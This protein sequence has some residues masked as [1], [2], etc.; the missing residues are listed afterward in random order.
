MMYAAL[1]QMC[2]TSNPT[3]TRNLIVERYGRSDE[4]MLLAKLEEIKSKDPGAVAHLECEDSGEVI[5][6][7]LQTTQ[8][9]ETFTRFPEILQ[10]DI[11]YKINKNQ[12]PVCD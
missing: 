7:L 6:I 12:M 1:I 2:F 5:F 8:M 3:R 4:E 11:T 10:T 9:R